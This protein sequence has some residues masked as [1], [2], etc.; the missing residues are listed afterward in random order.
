MATTQRQ[1]LN[2]N[3]KVYDPVRQ[4]HS[5]FSSTTTTNDKEDE[6]QHSSQKKENGSKNHNNKPST[7]FRLILGLENAGVKGAK[8][9][10]TH[11]NSQN[12]L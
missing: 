1:R 11:L 4:R 10:Q 3:N 6:I 7:D 5:V 8:S 2:G 9:G 12:L